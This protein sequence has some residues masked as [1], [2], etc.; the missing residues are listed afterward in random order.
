MRRF[1]FLT[2]ASI[3]AVF[4]VSGTGAAR[5]AASA[6]RDDAVLQ[7]A[8]PLDH[9]RLSL[10]DV[11]S[12]IAE[13]LGI[14]P[15]DALSNVRAS[16]DVQ[17][18]SG[19]A[20]LHIVDRLTGGLVST[21][22]QGEQVIVRLN[23]EALKT[24][25]AQTGRT[26]ESWFNDLGGNAK[27]QQQRAY[28]LTLVTAANDRATLAEVSTVPKRLVILVHGLDDPG[29][30]WGDLIPQ[31]QNA[32]YAIGRLEYPND[33]PIADSA[34]LFASVLAEARKA[35]VEH[36]DV[37]AHS[38]GGLVTR[39]V[40]TR[41][42]YYNGDGY[43]GDRYPAIDRVIMVGT[44]NHGSELVRLR[45]VTEV[46]EHLYRMMTGK[47]DAASKV[48]DGSGEAGIDLL[49]DSEF[50]RR[51]NERPLAANVRYTIIAGRWIPLGSETVSALLQT[52]QRAAES[53]TAP[54]WLRDWAS[55]GNRK[56]ASSLI[57]SAID[58]LGDGCVTLESAKLAGVDDVV[59]VNAN[60]IGMI[61]TIASNAMPPA[62][63]IILDRLKS[64]AD[65]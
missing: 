30:M 61:L 54:Q 10:R 48:G 35:G 4:M 45:G 40:L 57:T 8:L 42:A 38:M 44:P 46:G 52:T 9:G 5:Q 58:G 59:I 18:V 33:G 43:G 32:G 53:Q 11:L 7:F 31:L 21:A 24:K 34:D 27:Q 64:G 41:T 49:P 56:L 16:I 17:S 23:R 15:G 55:D 2:G 13:S 63:P 47:Q 51:L 62:V 20:Q 12:N 39:D 3:I 37:I 25:L 1:R 50:L 36:A 14:K 22:V 28:G 65:R 29:F 26:L 6:A 60:H 19:R